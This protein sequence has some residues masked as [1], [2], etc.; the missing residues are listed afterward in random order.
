MLVNIEKL[1]KRNLIILINMINQSNAN[2]TH[3]RGACDNFSCDS[4]LRKNLCSLLC[5]LSEDLQKE[6]EKL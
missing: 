4:C 5:D 1:S 2:L 6:L 3:Q